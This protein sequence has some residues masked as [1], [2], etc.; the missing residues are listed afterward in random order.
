VAGSIDRNPQV[1]D[2]GTDFDLNQSEVLAHKLTSKVAVVAR[3]GEFWREKNK[4]ALEVEMADPTLTGATITFQ[5]NDDDKNDDTSVLV[6]VDAL[7][8]R[9][10]TVVA[11]ITG[12]FGNFGNNSEAGPFALPVLVTGVTRDQFKAGSV[13][14]SIFTHGDDTWRFNFLVDLIFSDGAHLLARANGIEL[15]QDTPSQ[16]FGIE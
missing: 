5:T 12:A 1:S 2:F 9:G 10:R 8:P 3:Q 11:E 16:S 6:D 15:T 4:A 13:T 7:L 14:I